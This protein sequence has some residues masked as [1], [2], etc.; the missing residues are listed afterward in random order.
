MRAIVYRERTAQP[1]G[2]VE[3]EYLGVRSKWV[4]DPAHARVFTNGGHAKN[5]IRWESGAMWRRNPPPATHKY[6]VQPVKIEAVPQSGAE[7]YVPS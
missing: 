6:F 3:R 1:G 5:A 4:G 2:H 7:E